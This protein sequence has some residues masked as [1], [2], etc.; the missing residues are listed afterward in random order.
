MKKKFLCL[1]VF[2]VICFFINAGYASSNETGALLKIDCASLLD[3][4]RITMVCDFTPSVSSFTLSNPERII[5]DLLN[6]RASLD[7]K[8][9]QVN[10]SP[11]IKIEANQ[12]QEEPPITRV[13][14]ELDKRAEFN[15]NREIGMVV[16][17][18]ETKQVR[19][20]EPTITEPEKT[21]SM[22]V[23]DA[24]V[25]DLL[26]MIAMQFNLNIIIT[27]D[28]KATIT[29]RFTDIPLMS[30][31]DALVRAADCNYITY[32]SGIILIKPKGREIPGELDSRIYELDY[33]EAT[34]VKEAIKRV[35]SAR[36]VAEV[37]YR[38]V[39]DGGG[40]QRASAII[41]TDYP[42]VL[43][44]LQAVIAQL[45]Q[46]SPQIAIEAKF[47]ETSLS[48]EDMYGIDWSLRTALTPS[49]PKPNEFSIPLHVQEL[50]LGKISLEQL[51]AA[52]ELLQT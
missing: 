27:P 7:P 37:V 28:V 14:I 12:W 21:I 43:D 50:L 24:D 18:V 25:V 3:K 48:S 32:E 15:V 33:A 31:I 41:V 16:V 17:D 45:D 8:T 23:K 29:V 36:G 26:R 34:D 40:S 20:P 38:R 30:A 9:I 51:S 42:E 19:M 13:S 10:L 22:F 2:G 11:V 44:R 6:T 4:V 1:L 49:I 39:G 52:L 46:P 5:I 35:L 47:I